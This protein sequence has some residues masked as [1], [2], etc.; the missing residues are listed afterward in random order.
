MFLEMSFDY[1][2]DGLFQKRL[3]I[4]NGFFASHRFDAN[5]IHIANL[6][7]LVLCKLELKKSPVA[8]ALR[9]L[10]CATPC[11]GTSWLTKNRF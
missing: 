4:R 2:M 3:Q 6:F 9:H 10:R 5:L 7:L 1:P 8:L 11:M